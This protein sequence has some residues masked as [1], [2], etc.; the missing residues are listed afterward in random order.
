MPSFPTLAGR[1]APPRLLP[2]A[3]YAVLGMATTLPASAFYGRERL[4]QHSVLL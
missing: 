2:W 4:A 3:V 1:G